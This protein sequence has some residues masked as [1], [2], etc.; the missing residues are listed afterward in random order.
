MKN[1]IEYMYKAQQLFYDFLKDLDEGK[2]LDGLNKMEQHARETR[3][4]KR[5]LWFRF[6]AGDALAT[7]IRNIKRDLHNSNRKFRLERM[8]SCIH[9]NELE[10]YYS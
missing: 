8:E 4:K 3:G 9:S 7:T 10:I 5:S 1:L 6:S 2:L